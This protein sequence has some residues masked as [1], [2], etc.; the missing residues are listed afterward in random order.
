MK[1]H[2][3]F[4]CLIL[5]LATRAAAIERAWTGAAGDRIWS[6]AGNW[7]P[8]GAPQNGDSLTLGE[9]STNDLIALNLRSIRPASLRVS[10]L[11]NGL[12]LSSGIFCQQDCSITVHCPITLSANQEFTLA[13]AS[14]ANIFLTGGLNLNGFDL[15]LDLNSRFGTLGLYNVISGSGNIRVQEGF[16]HEISR[17]ELGAPGILNTFNGKVTIYSGILKLLGSEP[18]GTAGVVL[19]G[20]KMTIENATTARPLRFGQGITMTALGISQW[21]G[22]IYLPEEPHQSGGEAYADI[23]SSNRFVISGPI[24]GPTNGILRF[25]GSEIELAGSAVDTF[26]GSLSVM[27]DRLLLN[28]SGGAHM[29]A[30]ELWI[31]PQSEVRWQANNQLSGANVTVY[32]GSSLANLNAF[33][34][35]IGLLT[36]FGGTIAT[37]GGELTLNGPF[38]HKINALPANRLFMEGNL[39]LPSGFRQFA[40][41]ASLFHQTNDVVIAAKVHGPA[42]LQKTGDG[43]L[44]LTGANDYTGLTLVQEGTLVA[45]ASSALGSAGSGTIVSDG[46]TLTLS[47]LGGTLAEPISLRGAGVGGTNGALNVQSTLSVT[48]RNPTPSIFACLDLITNA[49][50]QVGSSARLTADGFISGL[51]PFTKTG[52]GLLIFTNANSNTYSGDTIVAEGVLELRKPNNALCM[53][54]NLVLGPA[55]DGGTAVVRLYQNAGLPANSI[56]TVNAGGLLDL[57]GTNQTFAGLNLNDGGDIQTGAGQLILG[58]N[59]FVRAG[60]LSS[61]GA[62]AGSSISGHLKLPPNRSVGFEVRAFAASALT[63]APELDVPASIT[64]D[65]REDPGLGRAGISKSG[66]GRMRVGGAND[67]RGTTTA[68]GGTLEVSGTQLS[69]QVQVLNG[70]R[71]Q[72]GGTVSRVLLSGGSIAPG[73]SPGILTCSNFNSAGGSGTFAVELNGLTAG[74]GYDRLNVQGSVRLTGIRLDASLGFASEVGHTFTIIAND[75]TDAVVDT[76]TGLP[77]GTKFHIG[78]QQFTISYTGD[79]GNDVVLTRLATPPQ[80]R[81][82]IQPDRPDYVRLLWP[83]N[84]AGYSLQ[85]NTNVADP[86]WSLA[87]PPP[88]VIGPDNVVTNAVTNLNFYRLCAP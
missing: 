18:L 45:G 35:T 85:F 39:R 12:T 47:S 59:A 2:Y 54:G 71:L 33:S 49:T 23:S 6:T 60:S 55:P 3:L 79:T 10:V 31:G 1:K 37:A 40:V 80:P 57:N 63:T 8:S 36:S 72:G 66:S 38:T 81:L 26:S 29:G 15:T 21:M 9:S 61:S 24:I 41:E 25:F 75:G 30:R 50:V 44:W 65:P 28:K 78:G 34:D 7:N 52:P 87:L 32:G 68:S 48:L 86:N 53:A 69:S 77:Q 46:A 19:E 17:V 88:V 51:G 22:P 56:A 83:T 64:V 74:T 27:S 13:N 42:S 76:F 82:V 70:A 84:A 67:Y 62:S 14:S 58:A 4:T 5:S 73:A 43:T 20:G 11:G 16:S